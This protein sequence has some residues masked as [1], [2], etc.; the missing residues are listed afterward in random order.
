M[1][2]RI[3]LFL[4]ALA[5]AIAGGEL[6]HQS[7]GMT[8]WTN[9]E[10]AMAVQT[11]DPPEADSGPAAN[12]YNK[13]WIKAINALRTEKWPYHDA[14]AALI[15]FAVCLAGGL[16]LLRVNT[17]DDFAALTTPRRAWTIYAIGLT[18]WFAYWASAAAALVEG[19]NRFEFPPWADSELTLIVFIACFAAIGSVVIAAVSFFVLRH[20]KLPTSLWIWRKDMPAHDWFYTI[21]AAVSILIA[22][23]VLRETYR[24]GH[25]LAIP[26][27]FLWAYAT[28]ATRAAGISK[29]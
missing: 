20:A 24:Y 4:A 25:W 28:L 13:R 5:L 29:G 15:A 23:E 6:L 16:L 9:V 22:L 10:K 14:G 12:A 27:M 2:L 19:F 11:W 18:G 17:A 21:G 7:Q 8:E 3:V 1:S 26:A